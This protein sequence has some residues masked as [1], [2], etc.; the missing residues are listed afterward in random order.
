MALTSVD[1]QKAAANFLEF[2]KGRMLSDHNSVT[3]MK[4]DSF[5]RGEVAIKAQVEE[6]GNHYWTNIK[7]VQDK[8]SSFTCSCTHFHK[9]QGICRHLAASLFHYQLYYQEGGAL[10]VSTSMNGRIMLQ[11]YQEHSKAILA[12]KECIFLEPRLILEGQKVEIE[13]YIGDRRIKERAQC[14][15]KD[16]RDFSIRVLEQKEGK[17]G[18]QISFFHVPEVFESYSEKV[19]N[20]LVKQMSDYEYYHTYPSVSRV[21]FEKI[22]RISLK[23]SVADEW[24][25]LLEERDI[26]VKTSEGKRVCHVEKTD[27][28]IKVEFRKK[29]RDGVVVS[30]PD[31]WTFI[32]GLSSIYAVSEEVIHICSLAYSRHMRDFIK[33]SEEE[34]VLKRQIVFQDRDFQLF[35][36]QVLPCIEG[37]IQIREYGICLEEMRPQTLTSSFFLETPDGKNII[38]RFMQSYDDFSFSPLKLTEF[39]QNI[40]RNFRQ[41]EAVH[42][43]IKEYFTQRDAEGNL[44]IYGNEDAV[45]RFMKEG[46]ARLRKI[47]EV[48]VSEEV[49]RMKI[50]PL[51]DISVDLSLKSGLLDLKVDSGALSGEELLAIL[52]SYQEKKKWYRLKNGDFLELAGTSL[53]RISELAAGLHLSKQQ[54]REKEILIPRYRALYIDAVFRD[55]KENLI[56][57][58]D[59]FKELIEQIESPTKLFELPDSLSGIM[60]EYQKE[61]FQWLKTLKR[62]GFG[63]ILADDMGLGKS[64]QII[65]FLLSE[66][67]EEKE[68]E[69]ALIVCPASLIYNWENEFLR[70]AP[71]MKIVPVVGSAKERSEIL[72]T[73]KEMDV[74]ITS[75]DL[76]RRDSKWYKEMEFSAMVIDEAQYIKNHTT[77]N[78]KAVKSIQASFRLALTGTPIENR[79]SELW[80]IFDFLMPGFLYS[81][82][83]FRADFETPIVKQGEKGALSRLH[84]MTGPFLMR[85]LKQD[86]LRDLPEKLEE[87]IYSRMEGTQNYLYQAA[88]MELKEQLMRE[89]EESFRANSISILA[90]LMRLRQLCCDPS[91]CLKDYEEGSAKLNT[92]MELVAHAVSSGHKL[93]LFSQFTAMLEKIEDCL[94]NENIRYYKLTGATTKENRAKMVEAFQA[95]DTPVFL[96][97]L[98]AGGT[99]LN[100]TAADIVIHYDPWWN[101]AAQNQATDR[102]HRIGQDKVV[103]VYRLITKDTIEDNIL[104]LQEAKNSLVQQVLQ[105]DKTSLASMSRNDLL[106]I[107]E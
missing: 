106:R 41:E 68:R 67:N 102:A 94:Q 15:L 93:L 104:K 99:G 58:S 80:S 49:K 76:L 90:Q 53:E 23:D 21:S 33:L 91:L 84:K 24:F 12:A 42:A 75:Y 1:I 26:I 3:E 88:V 47:G 44:V 18:Q 98:K 86:V 13:F 2:Q 87:I 56:A 17:Y 48:Y 36:S 60:R 39:P 57:R 73:E 25:S 35:C 43:I 97:S 38:C 62:Y 59:Y 22:G 8:I 46:I 50:V 74:F 107:L 7:M 19:A 85:R 31:S 28:I 72:K 14:M 83:R 63:G 40:R 66:K 77:Q 95:D 29:G 105:T 55:G 51:P 101:M 52:H 81:Y 64:L 30:I 6:D 92:C 27:P 78:A 11:K 61:G 16:L 69:P 20:L 32:F 71:Q 37:H 70:F 54:I 34:R 45:Y 96:I 89:T 103:T 65:S 5:W 10:S 82:T 4:C 100:L 79:L 9:E